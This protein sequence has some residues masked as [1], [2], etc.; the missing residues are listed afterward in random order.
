MKHRM[1]DRIIAFEPWRVIRGIKAVSFEEY[2]IKAPLGEREQLPLTLGLE[3]LLQLGGWLVILSSD[4][5][6]IGL[7]D[8]A[9]RAAFHAPLRPGERMTIEVSVS[10]RCEVG[11]VLSGEGRVGN[12]VIVSAEDCRLVS[13][14]LNQFHKATDL[15]V[16]Y[17]QIGP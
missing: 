7:L 5:T 6:Q 1:V 13:H 16:L 8:Q 4:F 10:E 2:C 14:R 9:Q 15:R 17:S 3:S 12:R 11:V